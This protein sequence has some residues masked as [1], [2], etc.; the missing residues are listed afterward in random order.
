MQAEARAK[1][2][3]AKPGAAQQSAGERVWFAIFQQNLRFFACFAFFAY[4]LL[5]QF[6]SYDAK[7]F[8]AY[9][10]A[11]SVLPAALLVAFAE[12]I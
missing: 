8:P 3:A 5:P 11:G 7:G 1:R 4:V 2:L 10:A 6:E 12:R 9:H